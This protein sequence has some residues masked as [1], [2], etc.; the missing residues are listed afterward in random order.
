MQSD[1][2][3]VELTDLKG[4]IDVVTDQVDPP[5]RHQE[6]ERDARV[7]RQKVRQHGGQ[8]IDR[9]GRKRMNPQM[10]ARRNPR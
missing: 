3:S 6:L 8:M 5:I 2:N 9:E 1:L 4:D 10:S 7:T